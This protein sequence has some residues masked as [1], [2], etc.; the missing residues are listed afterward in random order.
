[1]WSIDKMDSW[2]LWR[3]SSSAE[4]IVSPSPELLRILLSMGFLNRRLFELPTKLDLT[5]TALRTTLCSLRP[6]PGRDGHT[7][8]VYQPP[9]NSL[10]AA[11]AVALQ[12]IRKMAKN[13]IRQ[14]PGN[15]P[16][17]PRD[18]ALHLIRKLVK[19]HIDPTASRDAVLYNNQYSMC[20]LERAYIQSQGRLAFNIANLIRLSPA[21]PIL[22]RELWSIP[23]SAIWTSWPSGYALIHHVSK[24]L[25]SFSDPGMDLITFWQKA[26]TENGI[27]YIGTFNPVD[28]ERIWWNRVRRYNDMMARLCALYSLEIRS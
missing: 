21:C 20:D 23:P 15:Y 2:N 3:V 7:L 24:W 22:Y 4:R 17:V 12:L 13:P 1:M 6:K 14:P 10:S 16:L 5:W 8:L 18:L 25:E 28:E 26:R 11:R 19:N 9:A 27:Y